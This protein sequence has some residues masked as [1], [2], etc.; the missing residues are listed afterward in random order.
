MKEDCERECTYVNDPEAMKN[1]MP[2]SQLP[3]CDRWIDFATGEEKEVE[4]FAKKD[5]NYKPKVYLDDEE[6]EIKNYQKVQE[7]QIEAIEVEAEFEAEVEAEIDPKDNTDEIV[8][9]EI[10][11]EEDVIAEEEA[12]IDEEDPVAEEV[13]VEVEEVESVSA[14]EIVAEEV[15][16]AEETAAKNV[17]VAEVEV[18]D[19]EAIAEE[20]A[21]EEETRQA[22]GK[23]EL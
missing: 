22:V 4:G 7:E 23:D 9:E 2:A 14:A 20:I 6:E 17:I 12:L 21:D 8:A 15:A 10:A 13:E 18:S 11:E 19:E 5:P 3:G 1:F 16:A